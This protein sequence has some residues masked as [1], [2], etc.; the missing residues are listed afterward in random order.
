MVAAATSAASP[1]KRRRS[2]QEVAVGLMPTSAGA[3]AT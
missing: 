2:D 1:T 3:P